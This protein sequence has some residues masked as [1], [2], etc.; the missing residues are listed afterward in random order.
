MLLTDACIPTKWPRLRIYALLHQEKNNTQQLITCGSC[1]LYDT[2]NRYATIEL[3]CLAIQYGIS[4]CHFYLQGHFY[5]E[6]LPNFDI[7]TDHKPLL[8]IFEKYIFKVDNPRLRQLR[9][10]MQAFNFQVKWVPGKLHLIDDAL[11]CAPHFSPHV[12]KLTVET[13]F[14]VLNE[15]HSQCN[16]L[17]ICLAEHICPQYTELLMQLQNEFSSKSM[18]PFASFCTCWG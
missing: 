15:E 2:Q 12:D 16:Q 13:S 14:A 7:I 6:G 11:S 9:E 3:E 10:K 18:G 4:K 17:L 1:S 5:L 8:G